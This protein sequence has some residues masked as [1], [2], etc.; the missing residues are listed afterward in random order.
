[1]IKAR[2]M[3]LY[4]AFEAVVNMAHGIVSVTVERIMAIVI[5][6]I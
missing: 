6:I 3:R 4:T 5:A 2:G 1:M